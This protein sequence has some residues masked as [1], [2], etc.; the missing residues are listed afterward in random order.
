MARRRREKGDTP[1]MADDRKPAAVFRAADIEARAVAFTHPWNPR[2]E[3]RGAFLGRPAGLKRT[4]VNL[5]TVPPGKESFTYHAHL[6][7]E[8]WLY[9]LSG[10]A[11]IDDGDAQHEVV[12]GDFVAFPTPSQAHQLR[13]PY[14]EPVVYL[15]G[16]EAS[17][18]DVADFPRLGKRLVRIGERCVVY[19]LESGTQFPFPGIEKL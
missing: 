1:R 6:H 8:E 12:A 17:E 5:I 16:G 15:T 14:D 11:V 4:G 9:I 10:R 19:D 7:E 2:S 13:N 18:Q 3:M